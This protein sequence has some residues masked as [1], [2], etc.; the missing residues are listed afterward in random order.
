MSV[1]AGIFAL[2]L[3]GYA[4]AILILTSQRVRLTRSALPIAI[5][6]GTLTGAA[7]YARFSF[8][9]WS[10]VRGMLVQDLGLGWWGS[11]R[12]GYRC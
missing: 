8:H 12:S 5:G 11:S 2:V 1:I 10:G 6:T 9:L 7:M 4:A 3:A